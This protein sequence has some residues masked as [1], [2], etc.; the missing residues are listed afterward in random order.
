MSGYLAISRKTS[1]CGHLRCFPWY[2]SV[3][4]LFICG[5]FITVEIQEPLLFGVDENDRHDQPVNKYHRQ[6][7]VVVPHES[8][9][10][11]EEPASRVHRVS[12]PGVNPAR[13]ELIFCD[14]LIH[15]GEHGT[16]RP[17]NY[18]E[19]DQHGACN[20]EYDCVYAFCCAG[21]ENV[22]TRED[23]SRIYHSHSVYEKRTYPETSEDEYEIYPFL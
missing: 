22:I 19:C 10:R 13:I 3:D 17:D 4:S 23:N 15:T 18:P 2:A 6:S 14:A 9:P 20:A 11:D 5:I 1:L 16:R 21:F 8:D 12:D 7:P